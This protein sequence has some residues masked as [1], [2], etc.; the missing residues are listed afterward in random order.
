MRRL[1]GTAADNAEKATV[2]HR[3]R[4][5][6]LRQPTADPDV[7]ELTLKAATE[8]LR[9]GL[10]RLPELAKGL[11]TKSALDILDRDAPLRV[12][13]HDDLAGVDLR[14]HLPYQ[15]GGFTPELK[16]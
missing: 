9:D 12:L 10:A 14:P 6:D 4:L 5:I 11:A 2:A 15:C 3:Q 7:G 8:L 13:D 1:L 16:P